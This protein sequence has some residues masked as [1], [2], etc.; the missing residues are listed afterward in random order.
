MSNQEDVGAIVKEREEEILNKLDKKLNAFAVEAKNKRRDERIELEEV[1]DN[2]DE[3][4]DVP[5]YIKEKYFTKRT[6]YEKFRDMIR[7]MQNAIITPF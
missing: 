5:A 6:S 1:E 3:A 2:Y 4:Y 7:E